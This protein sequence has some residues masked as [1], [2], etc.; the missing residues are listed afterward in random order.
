MDLLNNRK[1]WTD[2]QLK[3]AFYLYCQLPFGKL[4]SKNQKIIKMADFI[5]KTPNAL[6]MKLVNLASLDP[7]VRNSGRKGLG[8]ASLADKR[9]WDEFHNNWEGLTE[10]CEL[11]L[12]DGNDISTDNNIDHV[13]NYSGETRDT[14]VSVRIGQYFF[15]KAVLS[16]YQNICCISGV[17]LPQLLIASHIVPWAASKEN[18]LN[19]SNGLC[20][21]AI[22]DRAFDKGFITVTPDY[23]IR[24]SK[25][26]GKNTNNS[27]QIQLLIDSDNRQIILPQKFLPNKDFLDWHNKNIFME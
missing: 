24:V 10:E 17:S 16:S 8:N 2:E 12:Q 25:K 23:I 22:H 26:L 14:I 1:P 27:Q 5:G 7:A 6:A 3:L 13:P 21:S 19:P 18:R 9:I 4:H 11:L 15:R 20:L